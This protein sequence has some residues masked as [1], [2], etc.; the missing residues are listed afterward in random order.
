MD[1]FERLNFNQIFGMEVLS[2]YF[3]ALTAVQVEQYAALGEIYR[4]WN[5]KVNLVSRKD[6]DALYLH[7]VLHSLSI[8]KLIQPLPGAGILDAGTGGGFPGIPLAI[9][10]PQARFTLADSIAKK[11]RVVASISSELKLDNVNVVTTRIESIH[12][13]FDFITARAVTEL[14]RIYGWVRKNIRPENRHEIPN[15][16]LYLKGGDLS[17]ETSMLSAS[18]KIYP[19]TAWFTEEYFV[20]KSLVHIWND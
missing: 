19:L 10:F 8:A 14:P 9:M 4:S 15:G 17:A 20:T 7:H 6:I 13:A 18:Y 2:R 3:D 12:D 11:T 5:D 1:S 16:L